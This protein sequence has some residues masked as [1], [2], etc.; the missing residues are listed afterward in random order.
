MPNFCDNYLIMEGNVEI[1]EEFLNA[2]NQDEE[3]MKFLDFMRPM[4]DEKH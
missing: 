2:A 4:P 1:L 3:N